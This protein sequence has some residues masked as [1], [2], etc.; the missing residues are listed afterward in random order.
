MHP[1]FG[2]RFAVVSLSNPPTGAGHAVVDYQGYMR[3]RIPV[4][5]TQLVSPQQ[6]LGTKLTLEG[7]TELVTLAMQCE[8]LCQSHPLK[9]GAASPRPCK[10]QSSKN[11][12]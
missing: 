11:S 4:S 5:A 12:K 1:L 3:L 2:R 10:K 9:S 8:V 6:Y 7:V